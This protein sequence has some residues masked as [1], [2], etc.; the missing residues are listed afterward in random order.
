[1]CA[2]WGICCLLFATCFLLFAV[3]EGRRSKQQFLPLRIRAVS[4]ACSW[5][6]HGE[7]MLSPAST[8]NHP[9]HHHLHSHHNHHNYDNHH[10]H[11]YHH[12]MTQIP[13][14]ILADVKFHT[15]KPMQIKRLTPCLRCTCVDNGW[16]ME[17]HGWQLYTGY[18]TARPPHFIQISSTKLLR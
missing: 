17:G 8:I 9:H 1:M 6:P 18:P 2:I 4:M 12:D 11:H 15:K 3:W 14:V 16:T 10:D 7:Q 13:Q 5:G